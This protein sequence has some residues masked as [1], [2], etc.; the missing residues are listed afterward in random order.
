M[1]AKYLAQFAS[2]SL[3]ISRFATFSPLDNHFLRMVEAFVA[4]VETAGA[5]VVAQ[6][7]YYPGDQDFSKQFMS[8]KRKGLKYAFGDSVL[9]INP[10][11]GPVQIDSLYDEYVRIAKEELTKSETKLDSADIPV[12]G[13]DG[14]FIPIYKEDLPFIAPQIAYSNIRSQYLGN[15]DWYDLEQLKKNKNYINGI[16]FVTDGFINEES[17]DYRRF[18]NEYRSSIKKTPS[19]YNII[20]YDSFRYILSA[21]SNVNSIIKRDEFLQRLENMENHI[22]IYRNIYLNEERVNQNLQLLRFNYGQIIP[23]N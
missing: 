21:I 8:L 11:L 19:L 20:G 10:E 5:E 15:G 22:G 1:R 13:I 16:I 12:T 6:E 3:Q 4:T 17:W 9:S 18:R 23:I 7:W 14:I 2:D